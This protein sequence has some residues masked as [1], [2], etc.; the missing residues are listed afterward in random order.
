M[1]A[2]SHPDGGA[3]FD[4]DPGVIATELA[5]DLSAT[6]IGPLADEGH[7]EWMS[8]P[9]TLRR[10]A[11]AL[12]DGVSPRETR[13]VCVG[14]GAEVLGAA[15]SLATGLSFVAVAVHGDAEERFGHVYDGERVAVIGVRLAAAD[16]LDD[17]VRRHALT[18]GSVQTVVTDGDRP[19]SPEI[20]ALFKVDG[21]VKIVASEGTL[22][23][24]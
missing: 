12:A 8:R 24:G 23:H 3:L 6:W 19:A 22:Q 7:E 14:P 11:A 10:V 21:D 4:R 20:R 2:H 1:V 15:V 16:V 18:V 5:A 13:I 17:Y 9:S